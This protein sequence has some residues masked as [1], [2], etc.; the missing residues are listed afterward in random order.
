MG[1]NANELDKTDLY[2][3]HPTLPNEKYVPVTL[4]GTFFTLIKNTPFQTT[5]L[6][7]SVM[8]NNYPKLEWAKEN[9]K[10]IRGTMMSGDNFWKG[11]VS[12]DRAVY[13]AEYHHAPDPYAVTEM[14]EIA[15][16]NT[17]YLYG[18][19][20]RTISLRAVVN[21]D[22]FLDGETP[23]SIWASEDDFNSKVTEE[24]SETLDVFA[25]SMHNLFDT[26]KVAIDAIISAIYK[27]AFV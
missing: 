5:D 26:A 2:Q 24:N 18:M 13:I 8:A 22:V 10:V 3:Q 4:H 27:R 11:Q 6:A 16:M 12:H 15:V 25:P 9:P 20:K 17:A 14:E 7:R 1:R 21:M 19:Q 23:E